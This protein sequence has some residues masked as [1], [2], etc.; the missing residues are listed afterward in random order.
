MS[1]DCLYLNVWCPRTAPIDG[2]PV[3]VWI[4]GNGYTRGSGSHQ[5]YDGTALAARGVVVVTINYRLG[6]AGFLA[7]PE[8]RA[9][10]EHASSGNYGLLDQIAALHWVRQNI[11]AFG[12]DSDRVTVFG[13][14][15][16]AT[17]TQ[18]LM[19]SPLATGLF[20]Q[21]ILHSPGSMRPMANLVTAEQAGLR[22]GAS[23]RQLRELSISQLWPLASRLVPTIRRLA[24]PRGMGP[25]VDGWVV[26]GND[27]SNYR[28]GRIR[29]LPMVVGTTENEGRRLTERMSISGAAGVRAYLES[30][31]GTI[32]SIP[33]TFV[34][35]DDE[36]APVA[37]D[38][39]VG[40][41]QFNYGAWS[42]GEEM[43]RLG[44]P[45]Y[46]YRFQQLI[47]GCDLPPTHDD[48]LPYVFGTLAAGNLWRGPLRAGELSN[49]HAQVSEAMISA[50]TSFARTG[51]PDSPG[52]PAWPVAD[53]GETMIFDAEPRVQRVS[54]SAGLKALQ[55]YFG[56]HTTNSCTEEL[57]EE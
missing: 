41:T 2:L 21:V 43:L 23:I 19:A 44:G 36:S 38:R 57:K 45:V 3:M 48:E 50:W 25:I 29:A 17:C 52:L 10:S 20:A 6:L 53:C 42:T 39:V 22:V 54:A 16:G 32:D 5:T 15:A 34:P 40:D 13:Q 11:G 26:L 1:E 12:G 9:E 30:S 4:H 47:P 35:P 31:F 24:S 46:R 51:T 56:H 14:S 7:H 37:L 28:E 49:G 55:S 8:L 33:D 27:V 18:L